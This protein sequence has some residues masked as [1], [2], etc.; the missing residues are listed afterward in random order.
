MRQFLTKSVVCILVVLLILFSADYMVTQGLR[1][2]EYQKMSKINAVFQGAIEEGVII[3]GGS[4]AGQ[5]FSPSILDSILNKKSYNLGLAGH[6]FFL[7]HAL[8]NSYL[9]K[10]N[11]EYPDLIIQTVNINSLSKRKDLYA[12]QTFLPYLKNESIWKYVEKYEG[13]DIFDHLIPFVRY[14]GELELL[15]VGTSEFFGFKSYKN[16]LQKGYKALDLPWSDAALSNYKTEYPRKVEP[17]HEILK[18][19]DSYLS[20]AKNEGSN[21]ILVLSPF[22]KEAK[23]VNVNWNEITAIYKSLADKYGFIYLDYSDHP[24]CNQKTN[25]YDYA[26]LN[27]AHSL[28]FSKIVGEDI[29]K[30]MSLK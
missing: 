5:H 12:Y 3:M 14:S 2:T 19:F 13:V 30:R 11:N 22:Y 18:L 24:I 25:F 8:F 27:L 21:V 4:D 29:A 20:N 28:E 7:Q 9:E 1:S 10:K 15:K 6:N 16:K 26:H 23:E 17:S